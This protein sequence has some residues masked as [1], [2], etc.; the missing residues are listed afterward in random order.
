M[1]RGQGG[2]GHLAWCLRVATMAAN[3]LARADLVSL[4]ER[5]RAKEIVAN[6]I[7]TRMASNDLPP[8]GRP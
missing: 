1:D 4:D 2:A 7:F 5:D 8:S 6:I 3:E